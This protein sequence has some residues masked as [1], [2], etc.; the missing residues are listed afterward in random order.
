MNSTTAPKAIEPDDVVV[1]RA[2]ERLVHAYDQIARADEQLARLNEQLAKLEQEAKHQP[3]AV[4][5]HRPS[6]GRRALRGFIGLLLAACIF[7]FAFVSQSSYGE[8]AKSTVARWAPQLMAS[9]FRMEKPAEPAQPGPSGVQLAA[10]TPVLP[11]SIASAQTTPEDV[12][13][14]AAPTVAELAQ[15][16]QTMAR[17]LANV[18]QGIVQL[19]ANQEQ[20]ARDNAKATEELKASQEQMTRLIARLSEHNKVSEQSPR[21]KT[22]VS[23]AAAV[24][25]TAAPK[26]VPV[27]PSPQARARPQPPTQ[28]QPDDDQ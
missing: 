16:L 5:G 23:S 17:D 26:P 18:E 27:R 4:V 22:S 28:L 8:A 21:P 1:A 19:K 24:P 11:Q 2:D 10:A 14:T 3:S 25:P 20:A 15:L 12:A 7:G 9:S 6:R 13:P